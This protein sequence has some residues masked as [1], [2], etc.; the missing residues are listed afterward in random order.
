MPKVRSM[1]VS[2]APLI[3]QLSELEATERV[4]ARYSKGTRAKKDDLSQSA[5]HGNEGGRSSAT[6]PA[7]LLPALGAVAPWV[8]AGVAA[9]QS[10]SI[11]KS[12]LLRCCGSTRVADA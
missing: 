10:E 11:G 7:L 12:M 5:D 9:G 4:L 3:G 1:D 2:T 6:T 8:A